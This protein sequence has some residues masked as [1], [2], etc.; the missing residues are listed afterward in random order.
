MF[1]LVIV[2]EFPF[3]LL[4]LFLDVWFKAISTGKKQ[5][6]LDQS[7]CFLFYQYIKPIKGLNSIFSFFWVEDRSLIDCRP[8]YIFQ[9]LPVA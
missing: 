7:I 4:L 3:M 6:F 9:V 1:R 8:D 2:K 5:V